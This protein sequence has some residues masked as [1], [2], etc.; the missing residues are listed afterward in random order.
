MRFLP[1]CRFLAAMVLSLLLLLGDP[2][3]GLSQTVGYQ[4]NASQAPNPAQVIAG[5]GLDLAQMTISDFP[6]LQVTQPL[7]DTLHTVFPKADL[8]GLSLDSLAQPW[9]YLT[10]G[11]LSFDVFDLEQYS[12][13]DIANLTGQFLDGVSL[14]DLGHFIDFLTPQALVS[15]IPTLAKLPLEQ[16][17]PLKALWQQAGLGNGLSLSVQEAVE[18]FPG[19][20]QMELGQLS[21]LLHDFSLHDLP[22]LAQTPLAKLPVSDVLTEDLIL[23]GL[24]DQ[25]KFA[26]YPNPPALVDWVRIGQIDVPLHKEE[27]DRLRA[28]SGGVP[29]E[30]HFEAQA[31]E[32]D[33]CIHAE[34]HEPGLGEFSGYAWMSADQKVKDGF[35]LLSVPWGG[36]GPAGNHPFGKGFRLLVGNV[37]EADGTVELRISF[38]YCQHFPFAPKTCTPYVLP[39]PEGIPIAVLPEASLIPFAPP[40]VTKLGGQNFNPE[41]YRPDNASPNHQSSPNDISDSGGSNHGQGTHQD[42]AEA[43]LNHRGMS[44]NWPGTD[45]GANACAASV[46]KVL[47]DAGCAPLANGSYYVPDVQHALANGR[48]VLVPMSEAQPGDIAIAAGTAPGGGYHIGIVVGPNRIISN[49]SSR[50]QWGW[51]SD[52]NFDGYYANK[53]QT[54]IYR[55]V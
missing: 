9:Q 6:P 2:F 34:I 8:S 32:G 14:S 18:Q 29:S 44:T 7:L 20:G 15:G 42:L 16:V 31:C 21:D 5:T 48:G 36:R 54:L 24:V 35:G 53:G 43:A 19:F 52:Y 11:T 51:V 46:Q 26:Q 17:P 3:K 28:I 40:N 50:A 4:P 33:G 49:S 22:R 25:L 37:N 41:I 39:L 30:D 23:T 10:V 1:T 27:H 12:L 47:Q 45:H 13:S 38:R 55:L